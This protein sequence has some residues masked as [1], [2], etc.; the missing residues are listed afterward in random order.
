MKP[1]VDLYDSHYDRLDDEVYRSIR[2]EAFGVDLGQES[3]IT[4]EEV[5]RFCDWLG[6]RAGQRVLEVACGSGGVAARIAA[7]RG[8]SVVG[9]DIN[10]L[11]IRAANAR[12]T[13]LPA[14]RLQF[15]AADADDSLP[16]PDG[17]FDVVICNDAI[18]HFRDRLCVFKEWKRVLRD[19]GRCLFTDPVVVTGM[20]SNAE[21][22]ARS[23]IGFFLFSCLGAN[24]A[25]LSAADFQVER[26][27]D[28]TDSVAQLSRRWRDAREKWR[29]QLI[30]LEGEPKFN[31]V[32]RFLEAAHALASERRLS[33]FVYVGKRYG[34]L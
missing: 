1:S 32:Q 16:F 23:S 15:L 18:N 34:T 30:Q 8:A 21:I 13:T 28:V 12:A 11:A 3:W 10:P 29:S 24:E 33:R 20:V 2:T 6:V 9:T 14:G 31:G 27:T 19:G 26:T 4:A 17:S 25:Q 22:E 7:K 5:D